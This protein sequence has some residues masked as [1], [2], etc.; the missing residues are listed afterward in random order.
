MD[1]PDKTE[2]NDKARMDLAVIC[3]RPTQ[4]LRENGGKLKA[5]Y[6]LK[7][8]QRKEVMKWMKDIK[9]PDGYCW[10]LVLKCYEVRT[11]QHK[12]LN[13]KALRPLKHYFPLDIMD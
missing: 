13:M 2:D 12:M 5:D 1:F 9:F 3:D 11:R 10:G 7:P 6:C 8:R 4:V